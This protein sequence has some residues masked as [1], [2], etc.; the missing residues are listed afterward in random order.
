M[1][2]EPLS[3]K[4]H[5][6][7]ADVLGLAIV[8]GD[9]MPG[10]SLPPEVQ[11]CEQLGISRT[12]LREAIRGL[13]GKGLIEAMPKRGTFVRDSFFW[14]HL[15]ADVLQWRTQTSDLS[16]YLEK[17]F[18]LRRATEPEAA[19]T[20]AC[21]ALPEDRERISTDFQAM[22]DA[23][24]DDNAWVEAD[25]SFHR[26]IYLATRNEFFWPIGQMLAVSLRQMFSIAALGSHRAR[27]IAEHKSLCDAIVDGKPDL[28]RSA[29]LS[30]LENATSDI[31]R[32]RSQG[33]EKK[34]KNREKKS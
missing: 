29:S 24:D 25:L 22:V 6:R 8:R 12:A 19:A 7:V 21:N 15:D 28:A 1:S 18:V 27:A 31:D 13:I 3:L 20:A 32:V 33:L 5:L 16:S 34:E 4:V 11:L 26:S 30:L 14:N 10:D 2:F 9:Y 23:G 17:M